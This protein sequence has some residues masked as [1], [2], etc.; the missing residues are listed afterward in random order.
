MRQLKDRRGS[1]QS[2]KFGNEERF[3]DFSSRDGKFNRERNGRKT[4]RFS[5]EKKLKF[6]DE[7][8]APEG[9]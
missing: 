2:G 7:C 9:I 4:P 8:G 1:Y 5:K 6:A 3:S